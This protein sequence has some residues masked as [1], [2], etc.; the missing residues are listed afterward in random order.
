MPCSV[1][2]STRVAEA[3]RAV[4]ESTATSN[5]GAGTSSGGDSESGSDDGMTA[6]NTGSDSN[7]GVGTGRNGSGTGSNRRISGSGSSLEPAHRWGRLWPPLV[8][9]HRKAVLKVSC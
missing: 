5:D 4:L 3:F 2:D 6:A 1:N 9:M 8:R 7:G